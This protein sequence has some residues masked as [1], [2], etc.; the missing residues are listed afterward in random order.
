MERTDGTPSAD[1]G[2]RPDPLGCTFSLEIP[3]T[4]H[5]LS[6]HLLAWFSIDLCLLLNFLASTSEGFINTGPLIGLVVSDS[7]IIPSES[8]HN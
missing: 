8:W 2:T 1:D 7:E 5:F 4:S 3:Q 6:K